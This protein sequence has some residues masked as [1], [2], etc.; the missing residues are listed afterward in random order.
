[1]SDIAAFALNIPNLNSCS[2]SELI[3]KFAYFIQ[4]VSENNSFTASEIAS[5]FNEL[6]LK[7]Y[8]NI[9]S[10]LSAKSKGKNPS[11]LKKNSGYILTRQEIEQLATEL[12]MPVDIP[13]TN[14]LIDLTLLDDTPYYIKCNAKQM[15]QCFECGLYDATLVLMRKLIETLIIEIF[16]R[17]GI[18][19][20]I[21]DNSGTFFYLSDL[22]PAYIASTKWN[23]SRNL[24]KNI[25]KVKKYGDLSAHN[26]RF[27][28]K[29]SDIDDFKF[30]LRQV[31]QEIVLAIDYP[32]W[33]RTSKS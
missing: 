31:I 6:S 18:D 23:V 28:A 25:I 5:C 19:N 14:V 24:D 3:P 11:F 27:L 16:E 30:E 13:V 8:S 2:S 7:P 10:Y 21:K 9:P 4:I 1:M 26:R 12:S 29:K 22:I 20:E 33:D 15:A 17:F 32:N